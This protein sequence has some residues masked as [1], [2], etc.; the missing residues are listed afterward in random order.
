MNNDLK[1]SACIAAG[2]FY[3]MTN[4]ARYVVGTRGKGEVNTGT[5]HLV[6]RYVRS[7]DQPLQV[8]AEKIAHKIYQH[9]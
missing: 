7:A 4:I 1:R 6:F 5:N 8:S 3:V 2:H 9:H